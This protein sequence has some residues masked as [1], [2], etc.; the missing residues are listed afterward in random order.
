MC[1]RFFA[2][3]NSTILQIFG[4]LTGL[5]FCKKSLTFHQH[6]LYFACTGSNGNPELTKGKGNSL[7]TDRKFFPN[8]AWTPLAQ[9]WGLTS[10]NIFLWAAAFVESGRLSGAVPVSMSTSWDLHADIPGTRDWC[11]SLSGTT[12]ACAKRLRRRRV[13][14][15]CSSVRGAEMEISS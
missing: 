13:F 7:P 15:S 10:S 1:K 2:G 5:H 8:Y 9:I 14:N 12:L 6:I 4:I 11:C 3:P